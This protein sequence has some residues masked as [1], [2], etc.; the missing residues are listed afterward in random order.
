[1]NPRLSLRTESYRNAKEEGKAFLF[2]VVEVTGLEATKIY[3]KWRFFSHFGNKMPVLSISIFIVPNYPNFIKPVKCLLKARFRRAFP[4]LNLIAAARQHSEDFSPHSRLRP[5][6]LRRRSRTQG[7]PCLKLRRQFN[8]VD[9]DA[10]RGFYCRGLM[11]ALAGAP[12]PI[13]IGSRFSPVQNFTITLNYS[14]RLHA[15]PH[16]G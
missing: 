2:Y 13:K 3:P 7:V 11:R 9:D 14:F 12:V 5:F 4:F 8:S 6:C 10:A 15:T 16:S 1:M